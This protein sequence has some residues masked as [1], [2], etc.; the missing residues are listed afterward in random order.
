MSE[1]S[2]DKSKRNYLRLFL[3][4]EWNYQHSLFYEEQDASKSLLDDMIKFKQTLRRKCPDLPFLIRIQLL[5]RK[6]AHNP[7]GDQQAYLVILST[8]KSTQQ[9]R[10]S[11]EKA[12]RAS[13]NVI[14]MKLSAEKIAKTASAIKTQKAH[15]LERFFERTKINRFT[16]LNKEKAIKKTTEQ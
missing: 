6:T 15:D 14:H 12:M 11:S 3:E 13:C 16:L 8:Q 4:Y 7:N 10:Q 2:E 1:S 9:I 5:K